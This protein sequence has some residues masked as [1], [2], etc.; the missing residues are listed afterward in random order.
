MQ[1]KNNGNGIILGVGSFPS[2]P[3]LDSFSRSLLNKD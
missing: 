1:E 2:A 3:E